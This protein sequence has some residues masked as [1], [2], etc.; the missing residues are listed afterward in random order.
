MPI[1][2]L[3]DGSKYRFLHAISIL[4]IAKSINSDLFQNCIAGYINGKL[5]DA[6]DIIQ[7][8]S[9][10]TIITEKD[11]IGLKIIRH[12]CLYLLGRAIKQLWP[13]SKMITGDIINNEFYYDIEQDH[14]LNQNDL[15]KLEKYMY[16]LARNNYDIIKKKVSWNQAHDIFVSRNEHYKVE[17]LE[18]KV[19]KNDYYSLYYHEEYVDICCYP[20][21][22]NIRFCHHFALYKLSLIREK[23]KKKNKTIQRIYGTAW[24]NQKQLTSYLT[25]V[26]NIAT[27]DHRK[28]GKQLDL[29]H[30]Q[31]D[32]PGIVFWH[33]NGW[34]LFQELQNFIRVKLQFYQYQEVKSPFMMDYTLWEKTGHWENYSQ[35]MFV[36]S[37]EN[38]TYC[39]KPMNCPGHVQI[40]NQGIKSYRDL[41][42]RIAEFGNCHRNEPSGSLHGLM[43]VRSFTQDDA[44][45]FCTK[46][47][48]YDEVSNCIKMIYDVY[49]TFGFKRILVKLSTR[50]SKRI[51]N[52]DIWD[53]AEKSLES[54]LIKNNIIFDH[55]V[56][57]GAFYGPKIEFIL[58]DYLDRT[59]QCGTIQLD[60]VLPQRLNAFYIGE[61]NNRITP[62]MI[63][64]SILGSIERFIGILTEEYRGCYPTWLSPI[65][66]IVM[67]ITQ[68]QLAYVLKLT[69]QLLSAH[70]RAKSDIRNEKI[71]FKIREHTLNHI[72]YMIICGN[73]EIEENKI[74]LRT[75]NGNHFMN[76]DIHEMIM[77]LQSEIKNRNLNQLE[78]YNY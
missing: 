60:F 17:M 16:I 5:A 34:I 48:I 76:I 38:R 44:H 52:D 40:F 15:K 74:T 22:P 36:T 73:K 2:T 26:S 23:E 4:D 20:N 50:P 42:I 65:Q 13:D 28:I 71:S 43:R 46:N 47:Q 11:I 51:G 69:D 53:N 32:A 78:E 77:K 14:I 54:A 64:R 18:Q 10:L 41:P 67:N 57:E 8:D 35:Q 1:I 68:N 37:S 24:R 30:L 63:H 62:I 6:S 31:D 33:H 56:G 27:R 58:L 70:I 29:Y 19:N 9:Y 66:V 75:R 49:A 39:I 3:S 61:R 25:S 12:S 72:P 7:D 55:Q 45:I 59:W 21:V